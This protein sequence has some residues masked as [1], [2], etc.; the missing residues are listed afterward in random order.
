MRELPQTDKIAIKLFKYSLFMVMHVETQVEFGHSLNVKMR[1]AH[2]RL[3]IG[4]QSCY[5]IVPQTESQQPQRAKRT[6]T[7]AEIGTLVPGSENFGSAFE[8]E[9]IRACEK[10]ELDHD[11]ESEI[12][13]YHEQE[14]QRLAAEMQERI[15][16]MRAQQLAQIEKR[17]QELAKV[18]TPV[19]STLPNFNMLI[20]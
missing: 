20:G 1:E 4:A 6:I 16:K 3:G 2:E 8:G 12:R 7:S 15:A 5:Q 19:T 17:K 14:R 18:G 9:I 13:L 10:V 11:F